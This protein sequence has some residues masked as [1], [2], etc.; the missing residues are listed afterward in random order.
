MAVKK[1]TVT[2]KAQ[3]QTKLIFSLSFIIQHDILSPRRFLL[4]SC[5]SCFV[6]ALFLNEPSLVRW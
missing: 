2:V 5:Q 4:Y 3:P 6:N 1:I